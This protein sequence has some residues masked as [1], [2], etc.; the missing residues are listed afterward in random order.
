FII[1]DLHNI[2]CQIHNFNIEFD[3]IIDLFPL[4][5][6]RE[7]HIS[8]GSWEDS[9]I[10]PGKKI[11]RDTHDDSVPEEVFGLLELSIHRCP[12]LKYV[13]LEQLSSGLDTLQKRKF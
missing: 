3:N 1:L 6:V 12:N 10:I 9:H 4:H 11:R 13:V 5:R 2:Y 8:G 7:I